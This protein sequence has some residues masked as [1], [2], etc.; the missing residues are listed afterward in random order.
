MPHPRGYS[1]LRR[2]RF[3][4]PGCLYFLTICTADR[5]KA[6]TYPSVGT[7][8]QEEILRMSSQGV[9]HVRAFTVLPDHVHLLA[10]LG[11]SL[12][13]SQAIARLMAKTKPAL[14][15]HDARWP[16][17]YSDHRAAASEPILPVLLCRYLNP[18]RKC[19][20]KKSERWPWFYCRESEWRRFK[21]HWA[22]GLPEPAW[23]G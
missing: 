6:L 20:V 21:D 19:L 17:N 15:A 22:D 1:A 12:S 4:T 8:I 23:L 16:E 11:K 13:L 7:G 2:G 3:S 10:E 14:L 5:T 9:W 18:Y